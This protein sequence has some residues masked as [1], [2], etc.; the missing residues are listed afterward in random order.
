MPL[1]KSERAHNAITRGALLSGNIETIQTAP[2]APQEPEFAAEQISIYF[3]ELEGML[4]RVERSTTH[5]QILGL[6]RAASHGMIKISYQQAL[7]LLYPCYSISATIPPQ[8]ISRIDR[9]FNKVSQS[10]S[11]LATFNRR[12]EYD[13]ALASIAS[14][15]TA[16]KSLE[17]QVA[18]S[19]VNDE[20][21]L[22]R[23]PSHREVYREFSKSANDDNRRRCERFRLSLPARVTGY[24]RKN[25]KWNEMT[26]TVDVSRTGLT[27]KLRKRMRH[28]MIVYIT[29]PYP[30]KLRSHG[31]S[32]ST[33]NVYALVRRVEPPRKGSRMIGLEFLGEHPPAGYLDRPWAVFRTK[34][35][36]GTE[37]RRVA[38]VERSEMVR[39]E[40]FT[41]EMQS[42]TR[43]EAR[44]ENLSPS[45]LRVAV[46]TAPPEFD[47]IRVSCPSRGFESLAA[48]RNRY[49]AKDGYERLCLQFVDK[50]WPF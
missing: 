34:K 32:D 2:G 39:L 20:G 6:E 33:Y 40:Y 42:I 8:M 3:L 36:N 50:E 26:E 44:T 11:T 27:L 1:T 14:R 17:L 37:R 24:D 18:P 10:F 41:D 12:K 15:P 28:G 19:A 48:V 30:I 7:A 4:N 43:E 35:W 29:L 22:T 46:K 38:R 5:Y 23:L 31:Y 16:T 9:A 47:L 21:T 45:G 25:G 13:L 49:I